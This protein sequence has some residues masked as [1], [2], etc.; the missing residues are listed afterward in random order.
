MSANLQEGEK[1]RNGDYHV[2]ARDRLSRAKVTSYRRQIKNAKHSVEQG[3]DGS[4]KWSTMTLETKYSSVRVFS[5][6]SLAEPR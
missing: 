4:I 5:L 2:S 6:P 3:E 1:R